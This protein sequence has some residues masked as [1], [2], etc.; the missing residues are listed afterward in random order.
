MG[1]KDYADGYIESKASDSKTRIEALRDQFV[2]QPA[3]FSGSLVDFK[4]RM[5]FI[6]RLSRPAKNT[7]SNGGFSFTVPPVCHIRLGDWFNHDIIINSVSYDHT[8]VPWTLEDGKNQ[9]M[10]ANITINFHI[11]G[12]VGNFKMTNGTPLTS[13]DK[14]GFFGSSV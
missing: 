10:W 1:A 14:T 4:K 7:L 2:F 5:E 3:Y 8:D 12:R 9:P 6:A 13:N 11:V